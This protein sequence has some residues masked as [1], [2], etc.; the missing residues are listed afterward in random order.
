MPT[1]VVGESE[2]EAIQE[3]RNLKEFKYACVGYSVFLEKNHQS[4]DQKD[5]QA[6]LPFCVGLEVM[7]PLC[8]H[9]NGI[10]SLYEPASS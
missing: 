7:T 8:L 4:S 6:E 1:S 10:T 9:L 5:R 3:G 2:S